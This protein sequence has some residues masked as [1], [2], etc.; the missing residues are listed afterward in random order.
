MTEPLLRV[1]N[2]VKHFPI[3]G[4]IFQRQ[5][6]KVHAVDGVSFEVS[7]G[8][9]MALVGESG[10]GKSTLGR[11]LLRLIEPTSGRVWFDGQD[12]TALTPARLRAKR[13]EFQMIFQD[14]YSSLNPRMTVG[15][16]LTEPLAL[17]GLAKAG[18]VSGPRNC[19]NRWVCHRPT[20]SAIRMNFQA[21]SANALASR[22][23]WRPSRG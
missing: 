19:S 2:L 16:T 10:C 23:P 3:K 1:K 15:Q 9:T 11:L 8:Q 21:G 12:L 18:G 5:V 17:L 20:S 22:G 4:G 14:P 13:R 7:A 6:D